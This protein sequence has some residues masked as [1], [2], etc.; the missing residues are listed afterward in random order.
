M[1]R[2]LAACALRAARYGRLLMSWDVPAV[3]SIKPLR[4]AGQSALQS[5]WVRAT[6]R[7]STNQMFSESC[8]L[9]SELGS[10]RGLVCFPHCGAALG[11]QLLQLGVFG[12]GS[13]ED[14]DVGV[15]V[16]PQR[17]EILICGAGFRGVTLHGIG[18]GEA[19]MS[20][21]PCRTIP[22][23]PAMVEEF[24][25]LASRC[26]ALLRAQV[27]LGADVHGIQAGVSSAHT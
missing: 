3:L 5:Q 15:G 6:D 26:L 16:L 23:Q 17:E 27:S 19:E 11:A 10:F 7:L 1:L 8:P 4:I 25:E 9:G 13:D 2:G 20:K 24:L 12:L 21:R 14:G 22:Q 18:A